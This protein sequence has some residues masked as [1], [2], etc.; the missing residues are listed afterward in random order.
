MRLTFLG[1]CAGTE[2]MPDNLHTSLLLEAGDHLYFFDAGE[3]C[4][5]TAHLLGHD[6]TRVR[7][8]FLSHAHMDHVGG[9]PN[10]LWTVR[11]LHGLP[12]HPGLVRQPVSVYTP[13]M[14]SWQAM[15]EFLTHTEGN[16][17]LDFDLAAFPVTPGAIFEENGISVQALPNRHIPPETTVSRVFRSYSFRVE[18]DS[19]SFVFSGDVADVSEIAPLILHRHTDLVLVETGHHG[20]RE[21][22]VW[23]ERYRDNIGRLGFV[24]HGRAILNDPD[25]QLALAREYTNIP[26][27]FAHDRQCF[28]F[29]T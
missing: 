14:A 18:S 10:L 6:L 9:L 26:V 16:F 28:D 11:K 24:H 17:S 29:V 7:A 27:F 13:N 8:V 15:N 19:A 23:A 21:V 25:G 20:V 5:R 1:T 4:S 12:S 3:S 22:C 2:P